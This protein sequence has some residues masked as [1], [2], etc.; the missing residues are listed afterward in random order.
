MRTGIWGTCFFAFEQNRLRVIRMY[1]FVSMWIAKPIDMDWLQCSVTLWYESIRS[2]DFIYITST[3][4]LF[5][6]SSLYLCRMLGCHCGCRHRHRHCH[7]HIAAD[8][9]SYYLYWIRES[10]NRMDIW[11]VP[12]AYHSIDF[13]CAYKYYINCMLL[14]WRFS[15]SHTHTHT[16]TLSY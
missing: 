9:I 3:S 2:V 11:F 15:C 10:V 14:Y 16:F 6:G 12:M 8:V 13:Y 4:F 7:R 1:V 5:G